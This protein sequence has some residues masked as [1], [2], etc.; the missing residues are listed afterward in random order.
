VLA[1]LPAAL[2]MATQPRVGDFAAQVYRTRLFGHM[3]FSVW[4]ANWYGGHHLPG[5]SL[6]F[7][8]L[9]WLLGPA[10]LGAIAAV[11]AAA[12]FGALIEEQ[13]GPA[14]RPSSWWFAGLGTAS[15][16]FSGRLTFT[17]GV[18]LALASLL[19]L[20]RNR[21]WL[22]AG[23][24][25]TT[26]LA[27]PVAA[28]FLALTLAALGL[29]RPGRRALTPAAVAVAA[30]AP[31]LALF[32]LFPEGGS[33]PLYRAYLVTTLGMI[34]A[35][36]LLVPRGSPRALPVGVALYAIGT[37]AAYFIATPVG[38]NVGR[39]GELLAGP[40]LACVLLDS[41]ASVAGRAP[42]AAAA[43][44]YALRH[45]A[46]WYE[47]GALVGAGLLL[48]GLLRRPRAQLWAVG[49]VLGLAPFAIWQ[50]SQT[51]VD[52][53]HADD[54][55]G[56]RAGYFRPLIRFLDRA[57]GPRVWRVE[58]PPMREHWES[59]EIAD[60]FPLAR[61]WERQLDKRDAP[62]FYHPHSWRRYHA[63]L[64]ANDVRFVAVPDAPLDYATGREVAAI[65]YR[66]HY[67]REV[68][69]SAHWRVYQVSP[70][71]RLVVPSRGAGIKARALGPRGVTMSALSRGSALV[72]V[73]YTRYWRLDG[74]CVSRAGDWTRVTASRTGRLSLSI[75]V[76]PARLLPW[77]GTRCS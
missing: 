49:A 71:P 23:L 47:L 41:R 43:C 12:C 13:F 14:A 70:V 72:R 61:G 1:S 32:G 33:E 38:S 21:P 18:A 16:L 59:V 27:S 22:S 20:Q 4:D 8:P 62:L 67:L 40:L 42:L 30:L 75:S 73:R 29:G 53:R 46:P 2:Y 60:R 52:L 63:W 44:V 19:A 76:T 26:P 31:A 58:V 64:E 11:A 5:Y 74:G 37:V 28:L 3:P 9:G 39:L 7:P 51:V 55:V 77:S 48:V 66:A 15:Q 34:V 56:A 36:A 57:D 25:A 6:L 24:A 45:F 50:W 68:W 65:R 35:L 69:R 10:L 17:L 54:D